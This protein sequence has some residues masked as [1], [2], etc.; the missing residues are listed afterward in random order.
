MISI[1]AASVTEGRNG[2]L[3]VSPQHKE[4]RFPLNHGEYYY[5][6]L[7]YGPVTLFLSVGY[8]VDAV[9]SRNI[10]MLY[11][12]TGNNEQS[13]YHQVTERGG[14]NDFTIKESVPVT[15]NS[16]EKEIRPLSPAS[17]GRK[18]RAR[19]KLVFSVAQQGDGILYYDSGQQEQDINYLF[20]DIGV[21]GYNNLNFNCGQDDLRRLKLSTGSKRVECYAET[22]LLEEDPHQVN[23]NIN[24]KYYYKVRKSATIPFE[25]Q[26][27]YQ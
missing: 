24:L 9:F 5:N 22:E 8:P 23:L 4:I 12:R 27:L 6:D 2:E 17:G 11:D 26:T 19:L 3:V 16:F 10:Y 13:E 21:K 15:I 25:A 1:E 14:L 7:D 18:A 20:M